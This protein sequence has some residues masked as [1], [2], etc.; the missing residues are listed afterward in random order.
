MST[1]AGKNNFKNPD[2]C[3]AAWYKIWIL[4]KPQFSEKYNRK[5]STIYGYNN[6]R[7]H[8]LDNLV[9]LAGKKQNEADL[10]AL[11]DNKT[12]K[13]MRY[14]YQSIQPKQPKQNYIPVNKKQAE[15]RQHRQERPKRKRINRPQTTN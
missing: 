6:K 2:V 3:K 14:L 13:L 12:G 10:I 9:K 7:N 15:G 4:Y 5:T 11:Y 1:T 8:G